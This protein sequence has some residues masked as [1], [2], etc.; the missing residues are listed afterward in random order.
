ME[1]KRRVLEKYYQEKPNLRLK[2]AAITSACIAIALILATL[3]CL[4]S[5]SF[6]TLLFM[7]GCTGLFAII[8]VIL[9]AILVYRVNVAYHKDKNN[10]RQHRH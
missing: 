1:E 6:R 9:V 4:D 7:R 5:I 8:F 3:F 10:S 2:Y